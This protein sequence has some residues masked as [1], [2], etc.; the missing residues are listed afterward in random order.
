MPKK[1]YTDCSYRVLNKDDT[2]CERENIYGYYKE[3]IEQFG[4]EVT[5]YTLNYQTSAHDTIY[6]E[7]PAARYLSGVSIV[8]Y[9][10]LNEQSV[11][12]SQ[13]GLQS[14]DE[15]TAFIPISSFYTSVSSQWDN[16][17]EPKS[18]DV[19]SLTEYGVGRPDER[20]AKHFEITQRLDQEASQINALLGHYVWL[21][22]AK[23][24]DYSFQPGL[25]AE[26]G[27]AQVHDGTQIGGLSSTET[28]PYTSDA[29]TIAA[30]DVFDYNNFGD[31]DDVYGDYF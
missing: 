10:E 11:F 18:G 7:Q 30:E 3:Q 25:S 1:Y 23:R 17:P 22:K 9:I 4:Q 8:M 2:A 19:I 14:D 5:Y 13:F 24:L 6:G 29:D 28:K 15:L 27:S 20:G 31:N 26:D 21:I 16:R 12:L